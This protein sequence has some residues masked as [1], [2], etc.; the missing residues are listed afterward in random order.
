MQDPVFNSMDED[1]LRSL[2]Y[3][4]ISSP[5]G[6]EKINELTFL[7]APHL[8]WPV[9]LSAL[10]EECPSLCIGNDVREYLN[11][12]IRST[13]DEAEAI[14][15]KLTERCSCRA[16]PRFDRSSWCD[17]TSIYWRQPLLESGE[18]VDS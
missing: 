18:I 8:E 5:E 17:Y 3:E 12:P 16:M 15:Q 1:F 7:F 13:S 10:Q 14:F 9:Y 6:F 2:G 11:S 4:I